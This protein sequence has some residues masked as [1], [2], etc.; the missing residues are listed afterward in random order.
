M[1]SLN[2]AALLTLIGLII[3]CSTAWNPFP[4][5]ATPSTINPIHVVN[6]SLKPHKCSQ[7]TSTIRIRQPIF[8]HTMNSFAPV[9]SLNFDPRPM[10]RIRMTLN[11][12]FM[13][14]IEKR[15]SSNSLKDNSLHPNISRVSSLK[16]HSSIRSS[17]NADLTSDTLTAVVV[18]NRDNIQLFLKQQQH[19]TPLDEND[20]LAMLLDAILADLRSI[21]EKESLRPHEIPSRL[22]IDF[23]P[24]TPENGL[25]TSS[26][27]LCRYKLAAHYADRLKSTVS[28]TSVQQR[29]K[30]IIES[31]RGAAVGEQQT[32][33]I[34]SGTDSLSTVRLSRMI[35]KDLG[36]SIPLHILFDPNIT[37]QHLTDL[38]QHPSQLQSF[39]S[40][41][42]SQLTDEHRWN[43]P[44]TGVQPS[45]ESADHPSVIFITGTT[46]FVGAFLL[47]ELLRV[48]PPDCRMICLVR[49]D[50]P[51][52]RLRQT[53]IS[54]RIWNDADEHRLTVLR[55][56]LSQS[57]FGL[58]QQTFQSLVNDVDVIF[59][60][61][62][63]VNFILSAHQLAKDNV[64][65]TREVLRLA[66]SHPSTSIPV[67][68]I[69]TLSVL[70]SSS[71]KSRGYAQTKWMAESLI[72]QAIQAGLSAKIYRLGLIGPHSRSGIGNPRDLYTL[73][74]TA[75]LRMHCYP[76][77]LRYG[78]LTVLPVD[79]TARSI[80]HL[81][82]LPDHVYYLID[83]RNRMPM[84][85]VIE[86]LH[87]SDKEMRMVESDEWEMQVQRLCD[88]KSEFECVKKFLLNGHVGARDSDEDVVSNEQYEASVTELHLATID[89]EYAH[90]WVKSI[91]MQVQW[92][93]PRWLFLTTSIAFHRLFC[94]LSLWVHWSFLV[95]SEVALLSVSLFYS[96]LFRG[97]TMTLPIGCS[98]S[99]NTLLCICLSVESICSSVT[100]TDS[101]LFHFLFEL[102]QPECQVLI[103]LTQT[104]LKRE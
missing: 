96:V 36:V 57:S 72:N 30:Q 100:N 62:A 44:A 71:S 40:S 58:D 74:F 69:S 79:V 6:S 47:A 21:G 26:M 73:L 4:S 50:D 45:K 82:R 103:V 5:S 11:L 38:I 78:H 31:V 46:G 95:L 64:F 27:K 66:T 37:L 10:I 34:S 23:Q 24:F 88:E 83:R 29:L 91:W 56:D 77:T 92:S 18:P 48:Y 7:V 2:V 59:H 55:G 101:R 49:C 54:Y 16:V 28:T 61:G 85:E 65:G 98:S 68:F 17:S 87:Q 22:I 86:G 43:P 25:L 14:S 102:H 70:S 81:S 104:K 84:D 99:S 8:S 19:L 53:M 67:H 41:A 63:N 51:L 39:S 33:L 20:P 97:H 93:V 15:T 13:S 52:H 60:C 12:V 89:K 42:L 80:V 32:S 94:S 76:S 90:R 35:E 75:I 9:I 1:V 3:P